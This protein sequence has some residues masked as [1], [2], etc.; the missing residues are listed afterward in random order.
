MVLN[1]LFPVCHR[2]FTSLWFLVGWK[3]SRNGCRTPG[4]PGKSLFPSPSCGGTGR[5]PPPSCRTGWAPWRGTAR[6]LGLLTA[7]MWYQHL[8]DVSVSQTKHTSTHSQGKFILR[9]SLEEK[10][11]DLI[12]NLA[13]YQHASSVQFL[14]F[15]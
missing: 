5:D 2:S 13:V 15:L 11:A 3:T 10:K 7:R 4:W 12:W 8:P 6:E 14:Y 9:V 1:E